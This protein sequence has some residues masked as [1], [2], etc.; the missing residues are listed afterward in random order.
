MSS[1]PNDAF[2]IHGVPYP[3]FVLSAESRSR[4]NVCK[5]LVEVQAIAGGATRG[6]GEYNSYVW[7]ATRSVYDSD[8]PTGDKSEVDGQE[9]L[10]MLEGRLT[11]EEFLAKSG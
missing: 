7:F 10:A 2:D 4:W 3:G 11:A 9:A 6:S 5:R 1:Y 8:I